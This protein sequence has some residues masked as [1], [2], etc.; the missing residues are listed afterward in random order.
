MRDALQTP[1]IPIARRAQLLQIH[2]WKFKHRGGGSTGP[3]KTNQ[4]P[5]ETARRTE[6]LRA[7]TVVER[8]SLRHPL[9]WN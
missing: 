2:V 3:A 5:K 7:E 1:H 6:A 9:P 4:P 8:D